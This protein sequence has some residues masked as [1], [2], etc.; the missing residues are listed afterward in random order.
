MRRII[1]LVVVTVFVSACASF[2]D[3]NDPKRCAMMF[4]AAGAVAGGAAGYDY[5]RNHNDGEAVGIGIGTMV[6]SAALGYA[7][8]ALLRDEPAPP[9]PPAPE[10]PPPPP[11]PPA[12]APPDPC[13]G[14]IVLRGVTFAF[15]SGEITGASMA[16]LDF[17]AETLQECPNV[18]TSVEGHT[19]SIG[20]ETYNQGLSLRRAESVKNYL[21]SHGVSP[22]RLQAKGFG[23]SRPIA[24][25]GT[26]D[27][28]ALNRRVELNPI[29]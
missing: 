12:P 4:G 1:A 18:N 22:G 28:R 15:D 19:D 3:P 17:A 8:C 5:S 14:R 7:I 25:N 6:G 23:E 2:T 21:S 16:T 10:P 27:G 24:D 13:E 11:P 9:P 29:E 20:N 26:E